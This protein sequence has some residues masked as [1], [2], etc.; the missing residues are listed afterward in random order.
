MDLTARFVI[1]PF[2]FASLLT[3]LVQALGTEWGVLQHY[4][5]VIK[6]LMT[7]LATIV[8]LVHLQ[9]IGQVAS[10]A[11]ANHLSST[12]LH[13]VR[14][15]LVADASAALLVLLVVTALSVYK[16]RGKTQYA[17]RRQRG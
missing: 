4:W 1:V 16:P 12:S 3:G 11:A 8:L 10:V 17:R 13:A 7:V 9:P 15:Q 2:S 6:L 5:V 14:L